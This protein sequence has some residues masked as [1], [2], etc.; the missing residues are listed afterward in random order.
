MF[1][2]LIA[3]HC[4]PA[5]AGIKPGNLVT[6]YKKKMPDVKTEID[7]LN[8]EL[9]PKDIFIEPVCECSERILLFV[10]RKKQLHAYLC[11]QEIQSLLQSCSYPASQN[12]EMYLQHLKSRLKQNDFPHEIGAFLGYPIHDI[13]GFIYHKHSGCLLVGEWRVYADAEA[14]ARLFRQYKTCRRAIVKRLRQGKTL[15][16]IFCAAS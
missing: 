12:T 1:E 7:R 8:R 14:A 2:E 3:Q 13:Y 15:A 16:Q 4:G 6:C 9:N 11:K 5:L 10:Y